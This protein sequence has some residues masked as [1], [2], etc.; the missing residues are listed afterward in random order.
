MNAIDENQ[1]AFVDSAE[2]IPNPAANTAVK[3]GSVWA[4]QYLDWV[5]IE[6]Q[7]NPA[8]FIM[9]L[10]IFTPRQRATRFPL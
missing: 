2:V 7:L 1:S 9:D 5:T 8:R 4:G 3:E 10:P 6:P